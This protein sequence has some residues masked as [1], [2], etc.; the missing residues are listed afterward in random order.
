M[1]T[2]YFSSSYGDFR[3]LGD[4]KGISQQW[5]NSLY[6]G[7]PSETPLHHRHLQVE[8][9]LLKLSRLRGTS[10]LGL[11]LYNFKGLDY[12]EGSCKDTNNFER[13]S[14]IYRNNVA[15]SIICEGDTR[16]DSDEPGFDNHYV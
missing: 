8:F 12:W 5:N 6:V 1:F 7:A 14:R 11:G 2:A 13:K 16:P 15:L 9:S 4:R 3:R 10:T